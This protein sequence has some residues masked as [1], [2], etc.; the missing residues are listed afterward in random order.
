M[1]LYG[2]IVI[3]KGAYLIFV[4]W[5]LGVSNSSQA[6]NIAYSWIANVISID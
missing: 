3:H 4:G 5:L 2:L 1:P 6:I